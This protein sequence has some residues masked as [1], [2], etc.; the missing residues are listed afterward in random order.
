M[1]HI[2]YSLFLISLTTSFIAQDT[3][4]QSA[5]AVD[6][7]WYAASDA[8]GEGPNLEFT[9]LWEHN[10]VGNPYIET[11]IQDPGFYITGYWYQDEYYDGLDLEEYGITFPLWSKGYARIK[12]DV[13]AGTAYD[14]GNED[15]ELGARL[16][17]IDV[18]TSYFIPFSDDFSKCLDQYRRDSGQSWEDISNFYDIEVLEVSIQKDFNIRN[19]IRQLN[20]Q[21][22]LE[23]ENKRESQRLWDIFEDVCYKNY[24][25]LEELR[26]GL[27][28]L[29]TVVSNS[30]RLVPWQQRAV[31]ECQTRLGDQVEELLWEG[32]DEEDYTIDG[33]FNEAVA[34]ARNAEAN[35]DYQTALE[36]YT[37]AYNLKNQYWI[38]GKIQEMEQRA[39]TQAMAA[40]TAVFIS[41]MN[42]GFADLPTGRMNGSLVFSLNF[43]DLN[44]GV[45]DGLG[46]MK[47]G[48]L[49]AYGVFDYNIWFGP[50]KK[51]GLHIGMTA[52]YSGLWDTYTGS[53]PFTGSYDSEPS[54][55]DFGVFG[56]LNLFGRLELDYYFRGLA[57]KGEYSTEDPNSIQGRLDT[58]MGG[59]MHFDGGA[60]ASIY[61]FNNKEFFI[62]TTGWYV[63]ALAGS[64]VKFLDPANN[65]QVQTVSY[66]YRLEIGKRPWSFVLFSRHDAYYTTEAINV[67]L[68]SW[69]VGVGFGGGTFF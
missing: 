37:R 4:A 68:N 8:N 44:Y 35:G 53:N 14:C 23:E 19:A 43:S 11:Q 13:Y 65:D 52:S 20:D 67:G 31:A 45:T 12:G 57:I 40:G 5:N 42:E 38:R 24:D 3:Y 21:E 60:R 61:L 25:N 33:M 7:S 63:D 15:V 1:R 55:T 39:R 10:T 29:S 59:D 26:R 28:R 56:G 18:K 49:G 46:G 48:S 62:R 34:N 27:R 36:Q 58:P 17:Y 69:G 47:G 64:P 30:D 41:G 9:L 22:A 50:Y 6:L 54:N 32:D 2:Y 51:A 16:V 66:G